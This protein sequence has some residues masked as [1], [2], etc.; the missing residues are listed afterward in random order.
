VLDALLD[1]LDITGAAVAADSSASSLLNGTPWWHPGRVAALM[2]AGRPVGRF[3]ELHPELVDRE[4]LPDRPCLAELDLESLLAAA[5]PSRAYTGLPRYPDV[6]RDLAVV[7]PETLPASEIE[8]LIRETAGPLLEAV[9]LFDVYTGSPVP[10]G[11]RNL[12]YRLRFRAADRTLT[13]PEAEEIMARIR[14]ALQ[15]QTGGQLRA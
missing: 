10:P 6:E 1:D 9:E 3:G 15:S 8:R 11:H 12:A 7:L 5:R 4:R 13:A 14:T 2:L